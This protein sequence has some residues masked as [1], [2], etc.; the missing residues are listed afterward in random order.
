MQP[1]AEHSPAEQQAAA[2]NLVRFE[3]HFQTVALSLITAGL[4]WGGTMLQTS[5]VQIAT[6]TEKVTSLEARLA[7]ERENL[8]TAKDADKDFQLRD[9]VVINLASRVLVLEDLCRSQLRPLPNERR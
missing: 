9:Q 5:S 3:R 4:V 2:S 1:L 6:L 7:Y 8:Y